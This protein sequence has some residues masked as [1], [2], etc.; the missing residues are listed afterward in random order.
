MQLVLPSCYTPLECS[1]LGCGIWRESTC[2][3]SQVTSCVRTPVQ[4]TFTAD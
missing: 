4:A 2:Y 3:E 1:L